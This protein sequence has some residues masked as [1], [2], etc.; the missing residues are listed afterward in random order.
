MT[1]KILGPLNVTGEQGAPAEENNETTKPVDIPEIP[2][3]PPL[4]GFLL[5]WHLNLFDI[6]LILFFVY[7]FVIWFIGGMIGSFAPAP[8][9]QTNLDAMVA[10]IKTQIGDP[11]YEDSRL[12]YNPSIK[13]SN[14]NIS[15]F[16]VFVVSDELN[17]IYKSIND[18]FD[19]NDEFSN[20]PTN[21][22]KGIFALSGVPEPLDKRCEDYNK[23]KSE[24]FTVTRRLERV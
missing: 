3:V 1:K 6:L 9:T 7:Q 17:D 8:L 14:I 23:L 22:I 24:L 18:N 5:D 12:Q 15:I 13:S 21:K 2:S 10:D 4:P 20:M 11:A 19:A 16:S